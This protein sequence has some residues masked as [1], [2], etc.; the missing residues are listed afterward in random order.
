MDLQKTPEKIESLIQRKFYL[1]CVQSLIS[2]IRIVDGGEC[3]G[4]GALENIKQELFEI[5]NVFNLKIQF[6]LLQ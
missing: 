3:G 6:N 2:S 4:I 5:R 1:S